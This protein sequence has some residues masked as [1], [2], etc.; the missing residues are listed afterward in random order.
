MKQRDEAR[1]QH[2]SDGSLCHGQQTFVVFS[3]P[4]RWMQR[5]ASLA[6]FLVHAA[7]AACTTAEGGLL[8]ASAP[9]WKLE[10]ACGHGGIHKHRSILGGGGPA[11]VGGS[12]C[13]EEPSLHP[14]PMRDAAISA[15]TSVRGDG[16]YQHLVRIPASKVYPK[17]KLKV[18]ANGEEGDRCSA[19]RYREAAAER[20]ESGGPMA[21]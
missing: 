16:G 8:K 20:Q 13:H 18:L 14:V 1:D 4:P 19:P 12:V 11:A 10:T 7:S 9:A 17:L 15:A 6:R 3:F 21:E 2:R 5:T